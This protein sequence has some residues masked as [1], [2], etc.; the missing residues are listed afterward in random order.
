MDVPSAERVRATPPGDYLNRL[1]SCAIG[2]EHDG[3]RHAW[4]NH[5]SLAV[6]LFTWLKRENIRFS[7]WD[8]ELETDGGRN[9]CVELSWIRNKPS[10]RLVQITGVGKSFAEAMSKAVVLAWM[11]RK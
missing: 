11:K 7:I 9:V 1:V 4:S 5:D 2:V 3:L 6:E 8:S 10:Q